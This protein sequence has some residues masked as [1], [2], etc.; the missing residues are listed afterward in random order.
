MHKIV[1]IV[2]MQDVRILNFIDGR[3]DA[4]HDDALTLLP[5]F[6]SRSGRRGTKNQL[7]FNISLTLSVTFK[8]KINY[9]FARNIFLY[10][11]LLIKRHTVQKQTRTHVELHSKDNF[12][13][14]RIKS[15]S[16]IKRA[17]LSNKM[18]DDR[19]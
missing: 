19:C 8:V 12:I 1:S 4:E 9:Y 16:Q 5:F 18:I 6:S 13:Y 14:G 10:G 17:L 7:T 3:T 11:L 2:W 15:N